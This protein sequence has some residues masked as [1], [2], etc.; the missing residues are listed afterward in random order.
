M[1]TFI[2]ADIFFFIT[3]IALVVVTVLLI[4]A[5]IYLFNILGRIRRIIQKTETEMDSLFA[6]ISRFKNDIER[7]R[8]KVASAVGLFQKFFNRYDY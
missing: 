7:R 6:S 2:H 5:F 1:N 3:T 4:V 8:N